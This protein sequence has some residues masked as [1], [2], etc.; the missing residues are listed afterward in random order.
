MSWILDNSLNK[1]QQLVVNIMKSGPIPNHVG[2]IMD[3][4]RRY[5]KKIN[6]E[7]VV[8]HS[9]G[10]DKLSESLEW[11][12]EL[13]IKEVTVYAFSIE[14]FKRTQKEVE[15][16]MNLATEKFEKLL[17]EEDKLM[18]E[19]IC[20]RVIGDL[21]LLRKDLQQLIAKAVLLTKDN[22]KSFLN[23]AF[24]YTSREEMTSAV[25]SVLHGASH[26]HISLDDVTDALLA[27][28][29]YTYSN[30]D[31]LIR[32]SGE[33]RLSDFLLYQVSQ[34]IIYFTDVLW[35]EFSF[36]NFVMCIL[37]YQRSYFYLKNNKDTSI[38]TYSNN[39]RIE[40]FLSDLRQRRL[41]TLQKYATA[42]I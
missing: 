17:D 34:S 23:I 39:M 5:A 30:P 28:C 37:R 22:C 27:Q 29:L 11:C 20:V 35:P 31:L 36:W 25:K 14:N 32:T 42:E 2:I 12:K 38:S 8:G 26:N 15:E 40:L 16:L 24:A 9:R 6:A 13:G 41:D 21:T 7:K 18:S 4:N 1:F 19:G 3:G 10:F 33:V